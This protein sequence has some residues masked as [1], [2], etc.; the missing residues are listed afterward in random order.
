MSFD[1]D[2]IN[3]DLLFAT[4]PIDS[5]PADFDIDDDNVL[6]VVVPSTW[7]H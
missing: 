6:L 3:I 4:L 1:F 5:V 7:R 2:E